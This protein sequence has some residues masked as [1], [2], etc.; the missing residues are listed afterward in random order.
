M[1]LRSDRTSRPSVH[2]RANKRMT[3]V[4]SQSHS[5][6]CPGRGNTP[7]P[8]PWP[9]RGPGR[10]GREGCRYAAA[11][12]FL[13]VVEPQGTALNG[14][15]VSCSHAGPSSSQAGSPPSPWRPGPAR[16]ADKA[17]GPRRFRAHPQLGEGAPLSTASVRSQK[18][19]CRPPC[20]RG[21]HPGR[22]AERRHAAQEILKAVAGAP[23]NKGTGLARAPEGPP[24]RFSWFGGDGSLQAGGGHSPHQ[25]AGM[26]G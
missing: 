20:L 10:A 4:S 19:E 2:P 22:K 21:A 25:P 7:S 3:R 6:G 23:G 26:V 12:I 9:P 8:S 11:T 17:A 16:A 1:Q 24:P 13:P 5:A 15:A 18:Q 14:T